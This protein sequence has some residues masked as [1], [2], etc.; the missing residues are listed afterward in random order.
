MVS[1]LKKIFSPFSVAWGRTPVVWLWRE[2][3]NDLD[4]VLQTAS[5]HFNPGWHSGRSLYI[6][7][8]MY[9]FML[10]IWP[11]RAL[12]IIFK[13]MRAYSSDTKKLYNISYV[14]QLLDQLKIAYL[15]WSNPDSYYLFE[16]FEPSRLVHAKT[17]LLGN[18][19][20][21]LLNL[22]NQYKS[23]DELE[24]K[25]SFN[26]SMRNLGFPVVE[27][28][29]IIEKGNVTNIK[30][31]PIQL[32]EFDFIAK[33][34]TGCKGKDVI[35]LEWLGDGRYYCSTG[36]FFDKPTLESYLKNLS[37]QKRYLLQPRLI[38]HPKVAD[39]TH[40]GLGTCR[41]ITGKS[42]SGDI[43][44]I[45]AVYKMPVGE[46]VADNLNSGGIGSS[47][48][49]TTGTLG[50]AVGKK[51]IASKYSHHP[52]TEAPISGRLLPFW[53]E[54]MVLVRQA[55]QHID[56]YVFLG[57]DIGLSENG[58][59]ILETNADWCPLLVQRPSK[60]GLGTTSFVTICRR[61]V[62]YVG[63]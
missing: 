58:P 43:D 35:R 44:V 39:L 32:P 59:I 38:N 20:S 48:D 34:N 25:L 26:H 42:P 9:F 40:K 24:D 36:Q 33:P 47:I 21:A 11:V 62:D 19:S 29:A 56:G 46:G 10:F 14:R 6:S 54:A 63:A 52:D 50:E 60:I 4:S 12:V 49:L 7:K 53:Q 61:W 55:H 41:V 57:W 30:G 16:L 2:P 5:K 27:D 23:S 15:Y 31:N 28:L 45:C 22:V 13:G 18:T 17:F 37:T 8:V 1:I 51:S 3:K